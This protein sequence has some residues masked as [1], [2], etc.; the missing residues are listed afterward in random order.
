MKHIELF[1]FFNLFG[2]KDTNNDFIIKK[3]DSGILEFIKNFFD[4]SNDNIRFGGSDYKC[5]VKYDSEKNII[6][7]NIFQ[8]FNN[9]CFI[10]Y[11]AVDEKYQNLGISSKMVSYLKNKYR[12]VR[13][14]VNRDNNKSL[15]MFKKLGFLEETDL[16]LDEKEYLDKYNKISFIYN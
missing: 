16:D 12:K 4:I 6:A 10:A 3:I 8:V 9:F 14:Y 2:K 15:N 7:V 5:L 11:V 1:E 13:T